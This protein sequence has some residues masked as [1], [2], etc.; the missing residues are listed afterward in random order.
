M[1]TSCARCGLFHPASMPCSTQNLL[2]IEDNRCL[3]ADT[4]VAGR[5]LVVRTIHH[6]G[7]SV[8]YLARDTVMRDRL[9]VLKELR[10]PPSSTSA[11][12]REAE[13]WFAREAYIL[14]SLRNPLIPEFFSSFSES[15]G[16]YIV[17]E[18][19]AGENLNDVVAKRGPM[20]EQIVVEWALSLCGLLTYLHGLSE[21]V[22]FRDLKPANILLCD[23]GVN[24]EGNAAPLKVV[25]FGIARHYQPGTVGTVIGTPGYAPPEQ[26]QGL[27]TPESDIYALGATMHRLLTA[28]DPERGTPF[29][30]PAVRSLNPLV[31]EDVAAVVERAVRLDPARRYQSAT[32]MGDAV[33][34]LAWDSMRFRSSRPSASGQGNGATGMPRSTRA[35]QAFRW[36]ALVVCMM[37][38]APGL[39]TL[40]SGVTAHYDGNMS[41]SPVI[42]YS[43]NPYALSSDEP[44]HV[45]S[46]LPG[47]CAVV[48]SDVPE[49]EPISEYIGD[50]S[51]RNV[52]QIMIVK[53]QGAHVRFL[54][55]SVTIQTGE[56]VRFD[57]QT[58]TCIVEPWR[59][60]VG[61]KGMFVEL[62]F[63]APGDYPFACGTIPGLDG[64]VHVR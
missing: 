26:Y 61:F 4:L 25:D 8:V 28:Y 50:C 32:E 7:M 10:L 11:E 34:K 43:M 19:V 21:P 62:S 37:M 38:V 16:N 29:T 51:G 15:G 12:R 45:S 18:Y 5:Y 27:A 44:A 63:D 35:Q 54:P 48:G 22:L 33:F 42:Q 39:L 59:S 9:V 52:T 30:F 3:V 41:Q 1:T 46:A 47:A 23:G 13:A 2:A 24:T 58:S 36:T 6:G 14:S 40:M 57:W 49:G 55:A 60:T 56:V 20:D 17:Q 64:V 31:S 53:D